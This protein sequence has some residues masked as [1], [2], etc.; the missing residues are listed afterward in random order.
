MRLVKLIAILL[1]VI[2]AISATGQ[3]VAIKTNLL[4]DATLNVNLGA[5]VSVAPKWSVDLS[6]NFNGWKLSNGKRWKHWLLQPEARYWFCETLGG[7]F[8]GLHALG[9]QANIGHLN[10]DFK[11][12][13]T[14]FGEL[15]DH[16]YQ[17]WYYGAGVAYGYSWLLSKHWNFEAELGIGWVHMNYEKFECT[18]CGKS[19]AKGNHNYFGPT[20]VA[21]NLVYVF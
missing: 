4:Y 16:R 18:G 9:G 11:F 17:G 2:S 12:L 5:E 7:H 13:G 14:D 21:I 20:K 1:P 8:I 6:G 3:E 19:V 15:S 10:A